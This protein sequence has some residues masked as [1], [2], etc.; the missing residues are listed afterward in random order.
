MRRTHFLRGRGRVVLATV[1][2]TSVLGLLAAGCAPDVKDIRTEGIQQ[3]RNQQ[4]IESMATLRFALSQNPSDAESNYYMGLNYRT[5]A[6]RRFR[7]GDVPAAR[8]TLD[9]S[10]YYFTQAVKSWP[11]YMAAVQAK[12]EAMESRGKYDGALSVA[13]NVAS[14]NRGVA[15]HFVFLGDEYRERAEFDSALKAYKK[16]L[17]SDPGNA[18]AFVGMGKL[19]T[20]TGDVALAEDAFRRAHELDPS[21]ADA[22]DALAGMELDNQTVPASHRPPE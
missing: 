22:A 8:H 16:V 18:R 4:H 19:Y 3:F 5:L 7:D 12:T 13:E 2:G 9:Q 15:D 14:N 10:I 20:R 1:L 11:N 17:A 6:A 21:S